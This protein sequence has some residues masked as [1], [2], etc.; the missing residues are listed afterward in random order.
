VERKCEGK[1]V[2]VICST[3][4][5]LTCVVFGAAVG[6]TGL[7]WGLHFN[8]YTHPISIEEEALEIHT[9]SLYPQNPLIDSGRPKPSAFPKF[10]EGYMI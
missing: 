2:T 8:L 3:F 10:K 7:P 5:P 9:E 6:I 1:C 4:E